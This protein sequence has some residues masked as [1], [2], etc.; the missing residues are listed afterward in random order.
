L[1]AKTAKKNNRKQG[2]AHCSGQV[3]AAAQE[4]RAAV[5]ALLGGALVWGLIW[6]PYRVLRDAGIDGIAAT[7]ATYSVALLLGL[8]VG[9]SFFRRALSQFS[10]SWMLVW[11]GLSAAVSNLG[12]VLATLNGEV[13]RVLLLF[14]LAPLWTVFL[15]RFLLG[16][17]LNRTGFWVVGLSLAGAATLLWHPASGLP[18]P[19]DGADWL[20]LVAGFSFALFNVLSRRTEQIGIEIKSLAAFTGVI[21]LGA[22]LLLAGTDRAHLPDVSSTTSSVWLLLGLIG[23]V[24]LMVNLIVQYGLARVSANRAIVIM[25]AEVGIAALSSWLLADEAMGLRE[26][27]GGTMIVAA[28]LFSA[29]IESEENAESLGIP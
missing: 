27:M 12:Y 20:G 19:Q 11:L 28:S 16:E 9:L 21:V 4:G 26:A 2:G 3:L 15:S 6:Y 29:K 1:A 8:M 10:P 13:M 24:L 7:T 23:A 17:R 25:L 18:L 22:L 5:A 14:Y